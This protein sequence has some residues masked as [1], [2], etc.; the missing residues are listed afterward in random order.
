[1]FGFFQDR[2]AAN[3]FIQCKKVAEHV[4]EKILGEAGSGSPTGTENDTPPTNN[5]ANNSNVQVELLCNDQVIIEF[6]QIRN[7]IFIKIIT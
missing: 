2:L 1:M 6:I 7:K 3:D 4:I 5:N